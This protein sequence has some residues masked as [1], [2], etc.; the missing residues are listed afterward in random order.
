MTPPDARACQP[1][2]QSAAA[3]ATSCTAGANTGACS[4]SNAASMAPPT[5]GHLAPICLSAPFSPLQSC[6]FAGGGRG[7]NPFGIG[8]R[9][10]GGRRLSDPE[11]PTKLALLSVIG[12]R[13]AIAHLVFVNGVLGRGFADASLVGRGIGDADTRIVGVCLCWWNAEGCQC[14][15]CCRRHAHYCPLH[16]FFLF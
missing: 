15:G 10:S 7:F 1:A 2:A 3:S 12:A 16:Q 6:R 5:I 13:L 11:V 4:T 8:R 14:Y 9:P